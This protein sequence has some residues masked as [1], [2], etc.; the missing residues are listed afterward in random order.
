MEIYIFGGLQVVTLIG[1]IAFGFKTGKWTGQVDTT[2]NHLKD[3]IHNLPCIKNPSEY[4]KG[5]K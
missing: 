3:K 5:S 2:L 4:F 1:L